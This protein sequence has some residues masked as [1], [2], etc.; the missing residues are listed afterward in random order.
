VTWELIR[1]L[2]ADGVSIVLTTHFLDEAEQLADS[3]IVIDA[4]RVVAQG[5]PAELT[6]AG[7]EGQIRFRARPGLHLASL[8]DALPAGTTASETGAGAY[9]VSG[10]VTP[11]LLATLTAWCATQGVLAENLTVERR[12][13]EDVFLDV[14]GRELRA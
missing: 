12:T 5:T 1:Q 13:L 9:L 2:K 3:V 10:D 7:A 6:R 11:Q 4:G 14:T 8:L